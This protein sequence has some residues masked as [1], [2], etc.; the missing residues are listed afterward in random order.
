MRTNHLA[1]FQ[2]DAVHMA[3]QEP[4]KPAQYDLFAQPNLLARR[5]TFLN[6]DELDQE[7]LEAI[8]LRNN[9]SLVFDIRPIPVFRHP[10]YHHK[11]VCD[12]FLRSGVSFVEMVAARERH[13]VEER[14]KVAEYRV[15]KRVVRR[16]YTAMRKGLCL[17]LYDSDALGSGTV[18]RIR[19]V[20]DTHGRSCAELHPKSLRLM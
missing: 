11:Q 13:G 9:V 8:V 19:Y 17:M 14:S 18:G 2:G 4:L 20:V 10:R 15:D 7:M 5:F 6:T 3:G 16:I 12:F 1:L